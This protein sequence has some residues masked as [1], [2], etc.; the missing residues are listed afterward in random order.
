MNRKRV[1]MSRARAAAGRSIKSAAAG[2][3]VNAILIS[4]KTDLRPDSPRVAVNIHLHSGYYGD[5]LDPDTAGNLRRGDVIFVIFQMN[6]NKTDIALI[7]HCSMPRRQVRCSKSQD[8][9]RWPFQ[10]L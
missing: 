5:C 7:I 1:E 8:W 6:R 3:H 2:K 10:G 9:F 4:K